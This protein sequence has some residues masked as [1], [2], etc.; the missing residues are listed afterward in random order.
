MASQQDAVNADIVGLTFSTKCLSSGRSSSLCQQVQQLIT[1]STPGSAGKRPGMLC[2]ALGECS[3]AIGADCALGSNTSTAVIPAGQLDLCT[4]SGT[5]GGAVVPTYKA[6]TGCAGDSD[7]NST[8]LFCEMAGT[9]ARQCSC[10]ATSGSESCVTLVS[11]CE[12]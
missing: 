7:C 3:S 10:N 6:A 12:Q 2:S 11:D 4:V 8:A 9:V 1:S 5:S